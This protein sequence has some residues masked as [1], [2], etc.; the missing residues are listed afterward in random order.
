MILKLV[1]TKG[2]HTGFD[3]PRA[4]GNKKQTHHGQ[5]TGREET[6]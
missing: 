6:N 1:S 5:S 3:A 4:Q 2:S